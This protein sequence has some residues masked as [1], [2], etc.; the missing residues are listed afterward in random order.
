MINRAAN[1]SALCAL[2]LAGGC[3]SSASKSPEFL[4]GTSLTV[5]GRFVDDDGKPLVGK[6]I[7]FRNLR[8]FGYVDFRKAEAD[9]VGRAIAWWS[10]FPFFVAYDALYGRDPLEVDAEAYKVRPN[11]YLDGVRT[12]AL[13]A[14]RF[15][16]NADEMLRDAEGGIN[17][18]IVNERLSAPRF[19][20]AA[21]VVKD[22]DTNVGDVRLCELGGLAVSEPGGGEDLVV[23]WNAPPAAVRKFVINFAIPGNSSLVWSTET[24]GAATQV[25][26]PRALFQDFTVRVAVEAYLAFEDDR[27]TSCLT[28]PLDFKIKAP[29]L[30]VSRKKIATAKNVKFKINALTNGAFDDN[31]FFDAFKSDSVT[32][33]LE[34]V[35]PVRHLALQNLRIASAGKVRVETSSDGAAWTSATEVSAERFTRISLPAAAQARYVRLGF[36]SPLM[37]LQELAVH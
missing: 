23:S 31:G 20:R 24:D 27:K 2:V 36:S 30:P 15:K 29:L 19:G 21:F 22:R 16:V 18:V 28:S 1:L 3:G 7:S 34:S 12:D 8:A 11:Y 10:A 26:V 25:A 14:F 33:D 4:P 17:I 35:L 13:G 9:A 37:S 32:L 5:T 6:Q